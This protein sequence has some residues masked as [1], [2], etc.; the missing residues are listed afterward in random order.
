MTRINPDLAVWAAL[1]TI[2]IL[3]WT[4]AALWVLL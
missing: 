4:A 2:C 1:I 3:V